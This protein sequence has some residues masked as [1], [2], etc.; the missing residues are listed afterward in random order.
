[1]RRYIAGLALFFPL[2]AVAKCPSPDEVS[3]V[4][5]ANG[6][7]DI[8]IVSVNDYSQI[9]LCGINVEVNGKE[10]K[11]AFFVSPDLK[12]LIP[13]AGKIESLPSPLKG[14]KAIYIKSKNKSGLIGYVNEEYGV[15]LPSLVALKNPSDNTTSQN[16]AKSKP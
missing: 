8:K 6:V 15:F 2:F 5:K 12:F 1:M 4:L 7:N 9:S 10:I 14:Y 3:K 16:K 13:K 11:N